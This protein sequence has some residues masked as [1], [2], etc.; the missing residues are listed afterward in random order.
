MDG[1][2]GAGFACSGQAG[3]AG[4]LAMQD[5]IAILQVIS[6]LRNGAEAALALQLAGYTL[7]YGCLVMRDHRR[8]VATLYHS[9][10]VLHRNGV[11]SEWVSYPMI[12]AKLQKMLKEGA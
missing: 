5:H 1:F 11:G 4:G 12:P 6:G 3:L 2:D 10:I 8:S 9:G 7:E